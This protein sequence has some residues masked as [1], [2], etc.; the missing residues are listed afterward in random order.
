MTRILMQICFQLQNIFQY[1]LHGQKNRDF[2]D[3]FMNAFTNYPK[4]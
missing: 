4:I 2:Y 1:E 3:D